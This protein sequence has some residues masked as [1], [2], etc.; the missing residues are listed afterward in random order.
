MSASFERMCA[1]AEKKVAKEFATRV[2][3]LFEETRSSD[4]ARAR[5]LVNDGL[6]AIGFI[7]ER[8][9]EACGVPKP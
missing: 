9:E 6:Q 5:R 1:E 3:L 7:L 2:E 8:I 4:R